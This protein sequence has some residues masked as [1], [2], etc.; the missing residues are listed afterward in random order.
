VK[1]PS[2]EHYIYLQEPEEESSPTSFSGMPLFAQ[3]RSSPTASESYCSASEMAS[4]LASLS[5][6]TFGPSTAGHGEDLLTPSM[7]A[8]RAS[9]SAPQGRAADSSTRTITKPSSESFAKWNPALF[10]WKIPRSFFG[11]DSENYYGTW[12]KWGLM[13]DGECWAQERPQDLLTDDTDSGGSLPTPSG[14]NG[15]KNHTMGRIDEW[16]GSSNPLRGTVLGYLCLPEFEEMVMA[17][18]IGWTAL[19]PFETAK[20][21]SWLQLHSDFSPPDP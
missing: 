10:S 19:T 3:S 7:Q 8:S 20:F 9:E 17:W 4:F 18:P 5:G 13:V 15:G 21:Q 11:E 16:G 2:C 1:S 14:V 6:E 12:P